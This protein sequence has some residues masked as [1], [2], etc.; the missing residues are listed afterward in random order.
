MEKHYSSSLWRPESGV[1]KY[2]TKKEQK[3]PNRKSEHN[4]TCTFCQLGFESPNATRMQKDLVSACKN[5]P[6]DLKLRI[7]TA[8]EFGK[9]SE[10]EDCVQ[11]T[12]QV[13]VRLYK[14]R[15]AT[16]TRRQV[17]CTLLFEE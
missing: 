6:A 16:R 9:S 7:T 11:L 10:K 3:T 2:C 13:Q 5:I 17:N 14:M 15:L 12:L 4:A 8:T 1:W